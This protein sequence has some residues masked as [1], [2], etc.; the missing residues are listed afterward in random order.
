MRPL[1]TATLLVAAVACGPNRT[2][3]ER[4][5]YV[6][7][8]AQPLECVPNLDGRIDAS[9]LRAA[10]GVPVSFLVSPAAVHRSVDV[11]GKTTPEGQRVWDLAV[12]YADD[13]V[14]RV[15]ASAV[16]GK[17]YAASF[18]GGQFVT[19]MD[20]AGT[21]EAVYANDGQQLLL[22]GYASAVE[23]PPGG[24]TLVTYGQPV[25]LYRFPLQVGAQWVSVGEVRNATVRGLPY[26]GRDTYAVSI[27]G[28]G[29]LEL[30]DV[31]FT[32]VLRARTRLSIEPAVGVSLIRRQVSWLFECFGE[33]A[34]AASVDNETQDDFTTTSELRRLGF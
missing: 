16:I 4:A 19:P 3:P 12:D 11:V 5:D 14:A 6:A 15:A 28:A 23:S 27:D 1:A 26:A 7:A 32:Q 10:I 30:P 2:W 33:V 34:R 21:I 8:D 29:R 13:Q 24:Q 25:A 9:E 20:P 18:P 22:L 17:W 31:T